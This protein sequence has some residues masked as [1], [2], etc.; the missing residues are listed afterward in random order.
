MQRSTSGLAAMAEPQYSTES[1]ERESSRDGNFLPQNGCKNSHHRSFG[2]DLEELGSLFPGRNRRRAGRSGLAYAVLPGAYM[3]AGESRNGSMGMA[4]AA[5]MCPDERSTWYSAEQP[6]FR[7]EL[8]VLPAPQ[9]APEC[10]LQLRTK[11]EF[12]RAV[13]RIPAVVASLRASRSTPMTGGKREPVRSSVVIPLIVLT[14]ITILG[15]IATVQSVSAFRSSWRSTDTSAH[16]DN[17]RQQVA[18]HPE[19]GQIP[20]PFVPV[21]SER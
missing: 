16:V 20:G 21:E 9:S 19:S 10:E 7:R 18:F 14:A 17:A 2:A 4:E 5:T 12:A 15:G 11:P 8:N 3:K 6:G 1:D 13:S